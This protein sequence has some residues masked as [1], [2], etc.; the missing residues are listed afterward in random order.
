M[1]D[2]ILLDAASLQTSGD[3][4]CVMLRNAAPDIP[5]L[6]IK[7]VTSEERSTSPADVVLAMP[8]TYRK[9][10]NQLNRCLESKLSQ[11]LKAGP[12]YFNPAHSVLT[13]PQGEHKLS[14][15]LGKLMETLM[16]KPN[17]VVERRDLIKEVWQTDYMGDTRTLD[18]HIRWIRE[19]IEKNPGQ[20][21]YIKTVR[22]RG[23]VFN[24]ED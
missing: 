3:R 22:G 16:R 10:H 17:Q 15:K 13:T 14:P 12:F 24:P 5:I 23:Y 20:P 21:R 7:E 6:H 19:M 4:T 11:T 8:L 18:V 9:L 1:P 2:L